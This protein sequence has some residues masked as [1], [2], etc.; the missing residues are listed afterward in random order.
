[1]Y[2]RE[3][4]TFGFLYWLISFSV[5]TS[6]PFILL[7]I[8]GFLFPPLLFNK[9][10]F[11]RQSYR[12]RRDTER[13][14]IGQLTS[15]M[16]VWLRLGQAEARNLIQVSL[17]GAGTQALGPFCFFHAYKQGTGSEME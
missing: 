11:L 15:Q 17:G 4:V 2:E 7:Q 16:A 9:I 12:E 1:M 8:T 10:F 3:H 13:S 6:V 14:S 5:L